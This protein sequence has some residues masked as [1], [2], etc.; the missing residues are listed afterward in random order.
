MGNAS[1][2]YSIEAII[3]SAFRRES[4][5]GR[6]TIGGGGGLFTVFRTREIWP[7]VFFARRSRT[8]SK[9]VVLNTW[10]WV[11][12]CFLFHL[13]RLLSKSSTDL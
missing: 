7:H 10:V 2:C 11:D 5:V 8:S 6:G 12:G 1:L 3:G 9:T 13:R 4:A